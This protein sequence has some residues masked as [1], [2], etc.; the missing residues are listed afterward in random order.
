MTTISNHG[1]CKYDVYMNILLASKAVKSNFIDD[2]TEAINGNNQIFYTIKP[3]IIDD[4]DLRLRYLYENH[5]PSLINITDILHDIRSISIEIINQS[6]ATNKEISKRIINQLYSL[7][8]SKYLSDT[9]NPLFIHKQTTIE[10]F[11]QIGKWIGKFPEGEITTLDLFY[12]VSSPLYLVQYACAVVLQ[13][14]FVLNCFYDVIVLNKQF[15][16]D[17]ISKLIN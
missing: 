6:N 12:Y 2:I 10:M 9:N 5:R 13:S 8:V 4:V 15:L 7:I 16:I 3:A 1:F 17:S 14:L 11:Y